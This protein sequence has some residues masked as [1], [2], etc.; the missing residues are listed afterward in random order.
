MSLA[1]SPAADRNKD[2]ILAHLKVVFAKT[3]QVL[4]VGSGTGQHAIHFAA[5]LPNLFWQPT[6][7]PENLHTLSERISTSGLENLAMP[8]VFDVAGTTPPVLPASPGI[9]GIYT[10]NTLHIMS[11]DH[12]VAFF[13]HAG[14]LLKDGG[15]LVVYGP[16]KYG[17]AFTTPSNEAFDGQLRTQNPV[18]GIR[19][20]EWVNELAQRNGL[21]LMSDTAMPA[22]NQLLVWSSN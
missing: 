16:F 14:T 11:V 13:T 8:T 15:R 21:T 3:A 18:R 2:V 4:E 10:C 6:E 22:N 20:F 19:D 1:F 5:A 7:L 9:D 12:V 17:G